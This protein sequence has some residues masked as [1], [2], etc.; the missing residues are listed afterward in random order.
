MT[1]NVVAPHE[2]TLH[3]TSFQPKQGLTDAD[4]ARALQAVGLARAISDP[5]GSTKAV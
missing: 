2:M 1:D 3:P 4:Y 5:D